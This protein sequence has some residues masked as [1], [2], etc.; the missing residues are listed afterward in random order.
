MD[1][2]LYINLKNPINE[3]FRVNSMMRVSLL[4]VLQAACLTLAPFPQTHPYSF[5]NP[6]IDPWWPRLDK[7]TQMN[8]YALW[9]TH[10]PSLLA[11]GEDFNLTIYQLLDNRYRSKSAPTYSS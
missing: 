8:V 2:G 11:F 6:V 10:E 3:I 5:L 7:Q 9:E 4:L 1:G